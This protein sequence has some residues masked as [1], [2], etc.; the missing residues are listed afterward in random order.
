MSHE[1]VANTEVHLF[2][3]CWMHPNFGAWRYVYLSHKG[4]FVSGRNRKALVNGIAYRPEVTFRQ[5]VDGGE[6][7]GGGD[8]RVDLDG[9]G[10]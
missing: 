8:R 4:D 1:K 3:E 9:S 7:L 5:D 10:E 6:Y 2:V